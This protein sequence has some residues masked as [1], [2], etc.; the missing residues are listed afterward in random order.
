MCKGRGELLGDTCLVCST[1]DTYF[2]TLCPSDLQYRL[3]L[4]LRGLF[5]RA[6]DFN[7]D[8]SSPQLLEEHATPRGSPQNPPR[9]LALHSPVSLSPSVCY[10][11]S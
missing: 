4:G 1:E 11:R 6:L 5:H 8:A 10:R 3:L 7:S 2:L 9:L